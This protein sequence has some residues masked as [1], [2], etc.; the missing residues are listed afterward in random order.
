MLAFL[1][2]QVA[3]AWNAAEHS[4][5]KQKNIFLLR[6]VQD[7]NLAEL[8]ATMGMK[9]G[10]VKTHLYRVVQAVRNQLIAPI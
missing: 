5:E 3:L 4:P 2:E 6:F 1:R 8:A 9:L 10:T 7:M